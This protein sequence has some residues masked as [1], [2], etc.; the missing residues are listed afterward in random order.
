MSFAAPGKTPTA[1][2]FVQRGNASD[3]LELVIDEPTFALE[4]IADVGVEDV[5]RLLQRRPQPAEPAL[6]RRF[7]RRARGT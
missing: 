1:K 2:V 6:L 5:G 4:Q 7:L 3:Q